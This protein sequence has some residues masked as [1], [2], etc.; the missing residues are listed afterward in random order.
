M[1]L[2]G[3]GSNQ[4]AQAAFHGR[5][6]ILV[7]GSD[8]ELAAAPLLRHL[9]Q[10]GQQRISLRRADQPSVGDSGGIG[11]AAEDILQP[12]AF[13]EGRSSR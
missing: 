7:A 4:L 1:Q 13:I 6:D 5:V 12:Q 11:H 2:A 8:L 3:D 9:L 10:P